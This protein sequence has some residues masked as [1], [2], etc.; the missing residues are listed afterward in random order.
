MIL[1]QKHGSHVSTIQYL[2]A[3]KKDIS[4]KQA[5]NAHTSAKEVQLVDV[6]PVK[7]LLGQGRRF[8]G[9]VLAILGDHKQQVL[10]DNKA[11]QSS[12]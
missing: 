10:V 5:N 12:E 8:L 11:A 2:P 3:S 9:W 6:C 4:V 1:V 7:Y